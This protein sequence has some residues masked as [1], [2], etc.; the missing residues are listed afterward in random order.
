[1][2]GVPLARQHILDMVTMRN[3]VAIEAVAS[4]AGSG[5]DGSGSGS[6]AAAGEAA[7][8]QAR[9]AVLEASG[10]PLSGSL[11]SLDMEGYELVATAAIGSSSDGISSSGSSGAGS[12]ADGANGAGSSSENG[13]SSSS[14]SS[15]SSRDAKFALYSNRLPRSQLRAQAEG[16]DWRQALLAYAQL[17]GPRGS[18]SK[19]PPQPA[20]GLENTAPTQQEPQQHAA[21]AAAASGQQ[22]GKRPAAAGAAPAPA[23]EGRPQVQRGTPGRQTRLVGTDKHTL[24]MPWARA[25]S[26]F[27]QAAPERHAWVTYGCKHAVFGHDARR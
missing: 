25:W 18:A 8:A 7:Q 3:C 23:E 17:D 13:S 5:A 9:A 26:E 27:Q 19:A 20:A 6:A 10:I 14:S 12:R 22:A 24:G 15:S 21:T 4:N 2:P 1:M 11:S 16:L